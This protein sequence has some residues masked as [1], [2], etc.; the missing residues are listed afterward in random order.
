MT[1]K[2]AITSRRQ[3]FQM[4]KQMNLSGGEW[5]SDDQF[6]PGTPRKPCNTE[7]IMK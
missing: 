6:S 1:K 3:A 7:V 5:E 2:S 4:I